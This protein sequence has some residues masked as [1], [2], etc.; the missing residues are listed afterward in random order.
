M[1]TEE[2]HA[3]QQERPQLDVDNPHIVACCKDSDNLQL[4][5]FRP[6]VVAVWKCSVCG[7]RHF[8]A[9]MPLELMRVPIE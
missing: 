2:R 4:F 5:E 3:K 8:R 7:R 1:T 6:D 9:F